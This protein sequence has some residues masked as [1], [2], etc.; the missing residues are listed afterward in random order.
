MVSVI[1]TFRPNEQE[2]IFLEDNKINFTDWCH[3]H[4]E[5]DMRNHKYVSL[6]KLQ[7]P[8]VM[9]IMGLLLVL[10]GISN[11]FNTLVLML[12]FAFS[13]FTF[14]FGFFTIMGIFKNG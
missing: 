12:C 4:F 2:N 5:K 13:I 10:I 7:M 14:T 3:K 6:E 9:I 8:F 1:Q 11:V